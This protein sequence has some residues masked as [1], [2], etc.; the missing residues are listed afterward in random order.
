[1][2][3]TSVKVGL[4]K[5][6]VRCMGTEH[7]LTSRERQTIVSSVCSKAGHLPNTRMNNE[8]SCQSKCQNRVR[9]FYC[10]DNLLDE[11][12]NDKPGCTSAMTPLAVERIDDARLEKRSRTAV[13]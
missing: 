12:L 9:Y 5:D 3:P 8:A 10:S 11:L 4:E 7:Q 2:S 13:L 1:M 6:K